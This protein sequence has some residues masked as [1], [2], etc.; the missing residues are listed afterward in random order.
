MYNR[1]LTHPCSGESEC[2]TILR[3]EG[4]KTEAGLTSTS[5][6]K[7]ATG[8]STSGVRSDNCAPRLRLSEYQWRL[9]NDTSVRGR[10]TM[11]FHI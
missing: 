5:P 3:S 8:A 1:V 7:Y 10:G 9:C 4:P 2:R 6:G 11:G